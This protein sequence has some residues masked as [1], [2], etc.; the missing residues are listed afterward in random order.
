MYT[1]GQE[2]PAEK[3]LASINRDVIMAQLGFLASDWTEGRETGKRG[4]FLAGDYIASMLQLYGIKPDGDLT[5]RGIAYQTSGD[6]QKSYFQKFTLIKRTS[7]ADPVFISRTRNGG[8]IRSITYSNNIDYHVRSISRNIEIE[9]PLVF[10]GY[11]IKSEKTK[12]NDLVKTGINGKF[13][14]VISGSPAFL[15][16]KLTS[17]E[18]SSARREFENMIKNTGAAGIIE[19]DINADVASNAGETPDFLNMSPSERPRRSGPSTSYSL[20]GSSISDE[21]PRIRITLK[22]ANEI[23]HD[24]DFSVSDYLRKAET[25]YPVPVPAPVGISVFLKTSVTSGAVPVRNIIGK[26]EGKN[27]D[28]IIV[29]GAHY[30]HVGMNNGYIWNGADDNASGTVGVM[31]IARALMAT[32]EKPAKTIIIA[33][34]AAEEAGLLGSKYYVENLPYPRENIRLNINFDMISR[35]ISDDEPK[36]VTMTYSETF[37]VFREVTEKNLNEFNI[38]LE[39]DYQPSNNPPGGSDHRSFVNAG[40]PVLRFKPGHRS[41]YHTPFDEIHTINPDIME[42]IIK[43]SFANTWDLANT[44][45]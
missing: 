43:I 44:K 28:E 11:G 30:D 32:G 18:I 31:T 37:P 21:L 12:Y 15:Q 29:I 41:E 39:V 1:S 9:A 25:M 5:D 40:I 14:M 26:I 42:K 45:W 35:Y 36:K 22:T 24:A 13:I 2:Q 20:P 6:T 23:F 19:V 10:A 7:G 8:Y 17:G 34:W 33:F 4:E 27:P 3:G 38:D 16:D